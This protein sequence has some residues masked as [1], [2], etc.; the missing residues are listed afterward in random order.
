M[1]ITNNKLILNKSEIWLLKGMLSPIYYKWADDCGNFE[2][3]FIITE[4]KGVISLKNL[5]KHFVNFDY[6]TLEDLKDNLQYELISG[7]QY[8]EGLN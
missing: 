4:L 2:S 8:I 5:K 7:Y 3:W 6:D 1:K